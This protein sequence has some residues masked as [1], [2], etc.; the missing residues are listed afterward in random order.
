MNPPHRRHTNEDGPKWKSGADE[1]LLD[2][3]NLHDQLP[4]V[5]EIRMS[6]A[7]TRKSTG[8]GLGPVAMIAL[9][10]ICILALILGLSIGLSG[11]KSS[12]SSPSSS[13][14]GDTESPTF[15][16]TEYDRFEATVDFLSS[17]TDADLSED[18]NTPQYQAAYW[19]AWDDDYW[20][21]IPGADDWTDDA[22]DDVI[23]AY[24][25]FVERWVAALIYYQMNGPSWD[26][27]LG[28]LTD[29]S[30]CDW[31]Q[32]YPAADGG[33]DRKA[34]IGCS[35]GRVT[36]IALRTFRQDL[37]CHTIRAHPTHSL[38]LSHSLSNIHTQLETV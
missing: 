21:D 1:M 8:G 17:L 25:D 37:F 2:E 18:S 6:A 5:E 35:D 16:P 29:T 13:L 26:I 28:W 3:D 9:V 15:A 24:W 23:T 10:A 19:I 7:S 36:D 11:D 32:S 31:Q 38:T 14:V 34:G 20:L 30:I 27:E 12:N 22:T 33:A 4:S